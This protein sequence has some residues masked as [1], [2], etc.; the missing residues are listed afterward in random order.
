M[1]SIKCIVQGTPDEQQNVTVDFEG[2][3]VR[4]FFG[5]QST[6]FCNY[7][8]VLTPLNFSPRYLKDDLELSISEALGIDQGRVR[9]ECEVEF[10]MFYVVIE[11]KI[12]EPLFI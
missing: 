12:T 8:A 10:T 6:F 4:K 2:Y 9:M 11:S 7:C 3:W 1:E 5:N